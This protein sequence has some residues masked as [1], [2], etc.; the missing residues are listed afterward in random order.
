MVCIK[1]K[2]NINKTNACNVERITK[3]NRIKIN[4]R[5]LVHKVYNHMENEI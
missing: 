3:V 5:W 2:Q 4:L 1:K